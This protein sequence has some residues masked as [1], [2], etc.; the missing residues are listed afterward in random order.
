VLAAGI[1]HDFNNLL[2]SILAEAELA[3]WELAAGSSP[4]QEIK[5]IEAVATRAG[6]IVRELMIYAGQDEARLDPVD[7]SRLVGEMLE[8]LKIS[9]SKH[10][11]LKVDLPENLPAVRAN[12]V[13]IRQV[14]M[15]LITNA[16]EALGDKGGVISVGIS[17]AKSRR[18]SVGD[19][20]LHRA[21][22][23]YLRFTV[24]DTGTGMT[25]E[26][27]SR[28]FDPFYTT[29]FAGRGL[30]LAAVQGIIRSH[31]GSIEVTS[32]PGLGSRFEILL[33][34]VNQP[35]HDTR[36]RGA[37]NA[38]DKVGSAAGTVLVVEDESVLRRA[39]STLLRK[40]GFFV[41]E[42]GDGTAGAKQFCANE[43]QIDVILLDMTLP[44]MSGRQVLEEVRR[45]RPDVKVIL[46]SAYSQDAL[47][48][49]VSGGQKPW[50][51]IRKPYRISELTDVLRKAVG[52]PPADRV[53]FSNQRP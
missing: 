48:V 4:D 15:N 23:D 30:G 17:R 29:K 13:Q 28:I 40:E 26:V 35:A 11:T 10:A 14:V 31:G 33:P 45:I 53:S 24:S 39:V 1:A 19:G 16:S 8:L 44:G 43:T 2:G 22:G 7:L 51:Y 9:I 6:E 49:A 3:E 5:A 21:R 32:A 42:A 34:C 50:G 52:T 12:A 46:T 41:I 25:H 36:H 18:T 37:L 20:P 47:A 27:L 38:G